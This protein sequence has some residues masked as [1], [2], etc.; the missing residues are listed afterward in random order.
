MEAEGLSVLSLENMEAFPKCSISELFI[1]YNPAGTLTTSNREASG[2]SASVYALPQVLTSPVAVSGI[3][4]A[5][6]C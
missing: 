3:Q 1:N 2:C 6:I 4:V 5:L